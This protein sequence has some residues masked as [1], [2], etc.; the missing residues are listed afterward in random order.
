MRR[1]L[2]TVVMAAGLT[3]AVGL[4]CGKSIEDLEEFPCSKQGTCPDPWKCD[5]ARGTGTC[6]KP[7]GDVVCTKDQVCVAEKEKSDCY[8]ACSKPKDPVCDTQ[9]CKLVLN[10]A[11]NKY[12]SACVDVNAEKKAKGAA[13]GAVNECDL[14]LTC[15]SQ[16]T[17]ICT[18]QCSTDGTVSCSAGSC[19]KATDKMGLCY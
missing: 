12:V 19:N 15:F 13:C 14:G 4:S 18:P 1:S 11:R 7:C 6:V 17:Q 16:P 3:A 10:G 8:P 2:S 9:D 5:P